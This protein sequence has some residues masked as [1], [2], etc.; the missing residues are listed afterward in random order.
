MMFSLQG[1]LHWLDMLKSQIKEQEKRGLIIWKKDIE[2]VMKHKRGT[3]VGALLNEINNPKQNILS[4]KDRIETKL[5]MK[6]RHISEVSFIHISSCQ[7]TGIGGTRGR[8][9]PEYFAKQVPFS[10]IAI[11]PFLE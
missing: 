2:L 10:I 3:S 11:T 8:F 1:T 7:D 9:P 5:K 6:L 4:K